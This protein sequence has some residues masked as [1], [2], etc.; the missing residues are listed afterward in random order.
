[1]GNSIDLMERWGL[2]DKQDRISL[3][4]IAKFFDL[5]PKTGD[6]ADFANLWATNKEAAIEYLKLDI[7][8]TEMVAKRMGF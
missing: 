8:L 7:E 5:P 6:G 1:M 3:K 4:D 2:G